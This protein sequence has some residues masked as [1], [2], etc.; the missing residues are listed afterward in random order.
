MSRRP[1]R[2][3]LQ[4]LEPKFALAATPTDISLAGSE[5][6]ENAA[7]G[8]TVGSFSTS[9]VDVADTFTYDL[10][11]GEGSIDNAAFMI[12]GDVLKS[13]ASFNFEA[14]SSYSIRVRS[15]DSGSATAEKQF[16]VTVTDVVEP[17]AIDRVDPPA[18]RLYRAGEV[19]QFSVAL[20]QPVTV[21]G[22]PEI[23]LTVGRT[24]TKAVYQSG[25]GSNELVFAYTVKAR[26]ND[27]DGVTLGNA[28]ILPRGASIRLDSTNL[29][30]ALPAVNTSGV[31]ID[32]TPPRITALAV[33]ANG[34]YKA[35]QVLRFTATVSEPVT[36]AG[37][38]TLPLVVG[39]TARQAAY[40]ADLSGPTSLVFEYTVQAGETDA[41]GIAVGRALLLAG[42]SILDG[43]DNAAALAIRAPNLPRVLVDSAG[44]VV[45]SIRA[46]AARTYAANAPIDFI[47]NFNERVVVTGSPTLPVQIG[48][49]A[50]S[51][52]FI[53]YAA[54]SGNRSLVFRTSPQAGDLDTDG[55]S[56]TGPLD[57]AGA[58]IADAAN[59]AA[60]G[61]LP[62]VN[63]GGVRVDG[64]GPTITAVDD[65]DIDGSGRL[66]VRVRFS[67]PVL[68]RGAPALPFTIG[69]SPRQF[70]YVAGARSSVLTFRYAPRSTD[71]FDLE[72]TP[73]TA[74]VLGGGAITDSLGNAIASLALPT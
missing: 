68:V 62:S 42:G 24:R 48:T 13:A 17:L 9:D 73:G 56:I 58:V 6:A 53:G 71:N 30:L 18:S 27:S 31:R 44:P 19:L 35:G 38:P 21:V 14:R 66:I 72:I 5:I 57:L 2:L 33:P 45:T 10:V 26:D 55:V 51:A 52:A 61:T 34:S 12:E 40:V 32:T 74:L 16:T 36:V 7:V 50:R 54:R 8:T 49:A 37:V 1:F 39:T 60:A 69:G 15:T 43:A 29:P 22:R 28:I 25:S 65:P 41:N 20:T 59:N 3:A 23:A 47:V 67:E 63:L 70:T 11:A 64:V 46:P 4:Q